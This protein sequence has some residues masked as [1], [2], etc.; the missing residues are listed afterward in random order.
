MRMPFA[1]KPLVVLI[2][3]RAP[4][5]RP[6]ESETEMTDDPRALLLLMNDVPLEHDDEFNRWYTE[7]HL[8]ERQS[9]PGFLS[10]RRFIA[11]E[12][13][14]KYLALYELESARALESAEYKALSEPTEWTR[15][16]RGLRSTHLRNIYEEINASTDRRGGG[17]PR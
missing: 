15:R 16:I 2:S 3:T 14:P 17:L 13:A 7:E 11:L 1:V 6:E 8:P 9:L 10:S 5:A 4:L 12:G